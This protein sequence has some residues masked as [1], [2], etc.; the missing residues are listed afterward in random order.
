MKRKFLAHLVN[1]TKI[2]LIIVYFYLII[3]T[4]DM[5]FTL[6]DIA[7]MAL[8]V[9]LFESIS[10]ISLLTNVF[11][12]GELFEILNIAT[13]WFTHLWLVCMLCI[14]F[15]TMFFPEQNVFVVGLADATR[16]DLLDIVIIFGCIAG[17]IIIF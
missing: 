15:K 3:L 17:L 1:L 9:V 6:L 14:M 7:F 16:R 11:G 5:A 8:I 2:E 10:S 4:L 12:E 13:I